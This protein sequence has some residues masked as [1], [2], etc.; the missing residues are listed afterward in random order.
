[1]LEIGCGD[2][3]LSAQLAGEV[4]ALTAID[5]DRFQIEQARQK[6]IDGVQFQIGSGEEL[7]F[8]SRTFDIILFGYSLHHQNAVRALSEAQRVLRTGGRILII[9]PAADGEYTRLVN[10]FQEDE[11]KRLATTLDHIQSGGLEILRRD[12]YAVVYP[13]KDAS[14]LYHYF[15]DRLME[16]EDPRATEKMKAILGPK[17]GQRPIAVEDKVNIFL[18]AP[19]RC[20]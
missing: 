20:L 15:M 16:K 13:F 5:P 17:T 3:R 18:A 12:V 11:I 4:E 19:R 6:N 9:E 7:Q 8:G 1:M 2:G 14:A 10:V